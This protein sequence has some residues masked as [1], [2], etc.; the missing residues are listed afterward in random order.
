MKLFRRFAAAALAALLTTG[1][2]AS[3][4]TDGFL[5]GSGFAPMNNPDTII[6]AAAQDGHLPAAAYAPGRIPDAIIDAAV[7]G[8]Y[9]PA[10]AYAPAFVPD[11]ALNRVHDSGSCGTHVSYYFEKDL[12][13]LGFYVLPNVIGGGAM[14]D[15]RLP[16][17]TQSPLRLAPWHEKGYADEIETIIFS[18]GVKSIG[19]NAF[20]GL[21]NVKNVTISASIYFIG[22]NAFSGLALTDLSFLGITPPVLE[23]SAFGPPEGGF[24]AAPSIHYPYHAKDYYEGF[25]DGGGNNW[26]DFAGYTRAPYED[27]VYVPLEGM[28]NDMPVV[29]DVEYDGSEV[30]YT[31]YVQSL[32]SLHYAG[33][34][35]RVLYNEKQSA[36]ITLDAHGKGYGSFPAQPGEANFGASLLNWPRTHSNR[37]FIIVKDG[38]I[39]TK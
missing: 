15:Y 3:S 25:L 19:A 23:S 28:E 11:H 10:A 13:I 26:S 2:L 16:E 8:D 7:Q 30:S 34:T 12:K 22:P 32:N 9:R 33:A 39:T 6:A 20:Y 5:P 38:M 1:P 21:E 14:W 29:Y 4:A 37:H 18:E 35:V 36:D 31:V 24:P 17:D 27:I